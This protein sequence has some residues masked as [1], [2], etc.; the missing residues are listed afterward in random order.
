MHIQA[1]SDAKTKNEYGGDFRRLFP[2]PET[3]DTPWGSAWMTVKPGSS[4]TPHSHA[5]RE[6]FIIL[7]GTGLM[8]VDQE[9]RQVT[10][11]DVIYLPPESQHSLQNTSASQ[12]L[13]LLCIWWTSNP[14]KADTSTSDLLELGCFACPSEMSHV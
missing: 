8:T 5:E 14:P 12:D 2:W 1:A 11:G 4:S 7:D 9:S 13:E 6:T 3:V 10:K